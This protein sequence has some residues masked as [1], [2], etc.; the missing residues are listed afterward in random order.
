MLYMLTM[1]RIKRV[2]GGRKRRGCI[3]KLRCVKRRRPL[4]RRSR[5]S[6]R[7]RN[8]RRVPGVAGGIPTEALYPHG[9]AAALP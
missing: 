7:R 1:V 2:R 5:K 3:K 4:R 9:V 6:Y 8:R